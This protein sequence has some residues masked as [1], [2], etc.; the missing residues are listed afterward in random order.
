VQSPSRYAKALQ[1]P[2]TQF[3]AQSATD[4]VLPDD[5]EEARVPPV[6]TPQLPVDAG[7]TIAAATHGPESGEGTVAFTQAL[8]LKVMPNSG[9]LI[10]LKDDD[11][12]GLNKEQLPAIKENVL[13]K[14]RLL[15]TVP[16]AS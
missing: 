2:W 8:S 15:Q 12:S 10:K 1:F 7:F 11:R 13:Q 5:F 6:F 3:I 14:L 4:P 9:I 16:Q